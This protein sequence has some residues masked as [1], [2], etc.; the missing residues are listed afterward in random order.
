MSDLCVIRVYDQGDDATAAPF[1]A[2]FE[3]VLDDEIAVDGE[4]DS[5]EEAMA[6][7]IEE[8]YEYI[9]DAFTEADPMGWLDA[10]Q[11]FLQYREFRKER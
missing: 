9:R 7:A 5:A 1:R 10:R 11:E 2:F 6:A 4:F 3:P 8:A